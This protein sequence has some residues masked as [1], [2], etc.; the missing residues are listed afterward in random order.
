VIA[1]PL[2]PRASLSL[3][4]VLIA[5]LIAA[6]SGG[7]E[8]P[9]PTPDAASSPEL[10]GREIGETE[11]LLAEDAKAMLALGLSADRLR[12]AL[13]TL[14][15]DYR[16]RLANLG[17]LRQAMPVDDRMAVTRAADALVLTNGAREGA[18]LDQAEGRYAGDAGIRELLT[19][20]RVVRLYAFFDQLAA[21]KPGETIL[22]N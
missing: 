7:H 4:V 10:L 8:D 14:I 2:R 13:G 16:V 15:E 17:C 3:G 6:C 1:H 18:W 12:P 5:L 9:Q 20:L 19:E 21:I 11:A 22:C